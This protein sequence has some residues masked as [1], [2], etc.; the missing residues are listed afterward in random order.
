MNSP[1][2]SA[3]AWILPLF[4]VAFGVALL[5]LAF[6]LLT[7]YRK[8]FFSDPRT[9]MSLDVLGHL[10]ELGGPGYLGVFGLGFGGFFL[11]I[12]GFMAVAMVVLPLFEILRQVL[13]ALTFNFR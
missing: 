5:A 2:P 9:A 3:D 7:E 13:Y 12:G 6:A 8:L 10:L 11:A 1:W 4:F